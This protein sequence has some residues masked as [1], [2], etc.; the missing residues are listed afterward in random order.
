MAVHSRKV[1]DAQGVSK[2]NGGNLHQWNYFG[3]LNQ[4]FK[5]YKYRNGYYKIVLGHDH[6]C[7]D[8]YG[9]KKKNG[10]NIIQVFYQYKFSGNAIIM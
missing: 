4:K 1:I 9:N 7:M 6:K 10:T 3:G 8:V 5:F 2:K